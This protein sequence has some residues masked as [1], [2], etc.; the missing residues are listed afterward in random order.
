MHKGEETGPKKIEVVF[1][2]VFPVK[3]TNWVP[4]FSINFFQYDELGGGTVLCIRTQNVFWVR[5]IG[6]KGEPLPPFDPLTHEAKIEGGPPHGLRRTYEV[7]KI[8]CQKTTSS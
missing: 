4:I 2:S 5:N 3:N 6:Q 8:G 1:L 7:V